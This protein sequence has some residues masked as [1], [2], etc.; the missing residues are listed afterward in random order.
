METLVHR[1]EIG[2]HMMYLGSASPVGGKDLLLLRC[3]T[4]WES[5]QQKCTTARVLVECRFC[6]FQVL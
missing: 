2:T 3:T 6:S 1:K 4:Q 5:E